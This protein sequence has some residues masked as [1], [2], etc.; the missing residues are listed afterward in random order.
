METLD[1]FRQNQR[2]IE[3]F[4]ARTLAGISG[5]YARLAYLASLVDLSNGRYVHEGL[6]A[7]YPEEAVQQALAYCH[8]QV[9]ARV[10]EAPLV[11]QEWDL[12]LCLGQMEGEFWQVARRWRQREP[13]RLFAPEGTPAYLEELFASNL[14]LLLELM[15][16]EVLMQEPAA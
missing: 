10:L 8:E 5:D 14:R 12:R 9:F 7:L 15:L 13:Y 6:A 16:G 2:I 1:R 3:D 11:R 4:T